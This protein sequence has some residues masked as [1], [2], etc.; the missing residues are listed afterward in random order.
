MNAAML[1]YFGGAVG[2]IVGASLVVGGVIAVAAG[3]SKG[4]L[5]CAA[6]GGALAAAGAKAWGLI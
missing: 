1:A 6:L 4:G 2:L 5:I 3:H